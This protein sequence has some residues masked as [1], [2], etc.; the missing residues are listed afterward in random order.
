MRNEALNGYLLHQRPYQ[1]KRA[2]YYLFSEHFGVV[3]GVGKKGAPLFEPLQ[4]FATGKRELKTFSQIAISPI[5]E[6]QFPDELDNHQ[7]AI[8]ANGNHLLSVEPQRYQ[9]IKGQQQ[10][11][12]LYLNEI[13]LKLLPIEDPFPI[14]WQYYQQSLLTLKQPLSTDEL[15][16]CLRQFEQHLFQELGFALNL[17]QDSMLDDIDTDSHYRFLP[18]VG[19]V[20]VFQNND[21]QD[22]SIKDIEQVENAGLRDPF[23]GSDI[24]AMAQ[25]GIT[26]GTLNAWSRLYRQLIDHL[27][28]YQPLQSRLLWQQQQRYR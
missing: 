5:I 14:L 11:A 22:A 7:T 19:L 4:L 8:N 13:L 1:E 23:K 20:A 24:L 21:T 10:Y 12:A 2:L 3:H 17:T 6:S 28:D 27:V 25:S 18:D 16:L 9:Q 26:L 15:R